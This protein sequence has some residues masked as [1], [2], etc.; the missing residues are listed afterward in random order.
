LARLGD[1]HDPTDA[2]DIARFLVNLLRVMWKYRFF[3]DALS[4]LAQLDEE[5]HARYRRFET[6]IQAVNAN[7]FRQV[8]QNGQM[9]PFRSPNSAELVAENVWAV[10]LSGIRSPAI[11]AKRP[12][13]AEAAA[14]NACAIHHL[15]LIEPY[16][17][18]AFSRLLHASLKELLVT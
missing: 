4:H 10:W 1:R 5:M 16:V 3:F 17:S 13:D 2:R 14:V 8:I 15:S 9:R 7:L 11:R 12:R 6:E 18:A